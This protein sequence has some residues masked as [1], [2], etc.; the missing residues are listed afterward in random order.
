MYYNLI[1]ILLKGLYTCL[2]RQTENIS[3]KKMLIL[4]LVVIAQ[5]EL[6]SSSVS[7]FSQCYMHVTLVF[8][9]ML[10]F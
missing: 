8:R 10:F 7:L 2:H 6:F 1:L 9:K 5:W 3:E 4:T